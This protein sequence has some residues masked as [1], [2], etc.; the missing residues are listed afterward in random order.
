MRHG[1][2]ESTTKSFTTRIPSGQHGGSGQ[3]RDLQRGRHRPRKN[4]R[5]GSRRS[6]D[7][8]CGWPRHHPGETG[9]TSEAVGLTVWAVLAMLAVPKASCLVH[10]RPKSNYRKQSPRPFSPAGPGNDCARPVTALG[11]LL[12]RGL[13]VSKGIA[14][15]HPHQPGPRVLSHRASSRST[16]FCSVVVSS[17]RLTRC[18]KQERIA[19]GSVLAKS[20]SGCRPERRCGHADEPA[21][22][23]AS[24]FRL[25]IPEPWEVRKEVAQDGS[26]A[27]RSALPLL[28]AATLTER[29]RDTRP[30]HPCSPWWH[31]H[32]RQ[33]E[34]E[35]P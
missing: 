19:M 20:S 26:H 5:V 25:A 31:D 11:G 17:S 12:G 6:D 8:Q 18:P 2:R 27:S 21:S 30:R 4:D 13:S 9:R 24:V 16:W 3:K 29:P 28:R 23:R 22:S 15:W 7:R 35:L 1:R 10:Y 33:S 34:T 14:S 32:D